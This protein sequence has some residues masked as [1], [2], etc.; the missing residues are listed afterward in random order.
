MWMKSLVPGDSHERICSFCKAGLLQR[1][2]SPC[3]CAAQVPYGLHAVLVH[4]GQANAGH[5]WAYVYDRRRQA[6]L[7]YN[8]IA[9]TEASWEELQRDSFGGARNASAYCLLYTRG[10]AAGTAARLPFANGRAS[11]ASLWRRCLL[12]VQKTPPRV[13]VKEF[14]PCSIHL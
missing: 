7:K 14:A 11:S 12:T 3:P 4:E 13:E 1:A 8:D 2:R 5:Y 9:V 10:T 6:W